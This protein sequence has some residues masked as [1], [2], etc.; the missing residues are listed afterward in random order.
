M[1]E[2]TGLGTRILTAS[3]R[4]ADRKGLKKYSLRQLAAD[5][6]TVQPYLTRVLQ[7]KSRPSRDMLLRL[8][9]ALECTPQEAAEIFS[10][11][12]Y[13]APSLEELEE[14]SGKKVRAA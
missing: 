4:K 9:R 11:T 10:E 14:D 2:R 5:A 7:G 6:G 13:R 12:D 1:V 8:C 3:R